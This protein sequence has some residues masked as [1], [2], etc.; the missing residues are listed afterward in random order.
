MLD[1][2]GVLIAEQRYEAAEGEYRALSRNPAAKQKALIGL[3]NCRSLEKDY[4]AVLPFT[5]NNQGIWLTISPA[6]ILLDE[7]YTLKLV[8][9]GDYRNTQDA[10]MDVFEGGNLVN[11]IHPY[12]TPQDY[13]RGTVILEWRHE[14]LPESFAG[15]EQHYYALRVGGGIDSTGN[16]NLLLE[17]E[18]HYDFLKHWTLEARGTLDRSPAWNGTAASLAVIYRF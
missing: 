17:A 15:A 12:W 7:P 9:R 3:A 2:A 16:K 18:W 4:Q 5:D 10:S 1:L 13:T 6:F 11:I 14:L 8:V